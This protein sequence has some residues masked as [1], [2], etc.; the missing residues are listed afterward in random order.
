M[1]PLEYLEVELTSSVDLEKMIKEGT[2]LHSM[3]LVAWLKYKM[4]IVDGGYAD[5]TS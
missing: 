1:E 5:R 4:L 2:F 3:G